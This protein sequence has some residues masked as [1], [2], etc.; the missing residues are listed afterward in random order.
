MEG[1]DYSRQNARQELWKMGD[2]SGRLV[3]KRTPTMDQ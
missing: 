3:I 1:M 2:G